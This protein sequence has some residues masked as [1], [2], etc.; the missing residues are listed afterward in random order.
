MNFDKI[1][2]DIVESIEGAIGAA[3]MGFDGIL[4]AKYLRDKSGLDIESLAI[5]FSKV[6]SESSRISK[7]V[8]VGNL[9]EISLSAK[10]HCLVFYILPDNYFVTLLL[11]EG[12]SIG[13]GRYIL[14]RNASELIAQF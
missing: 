4:V 5:E 13:K 11:N 9:M 8:N 1:L 12:A 6:I 2:K 10:D 3:V 7:S 14:K